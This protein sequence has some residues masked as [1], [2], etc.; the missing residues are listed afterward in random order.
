MALILWSSILL[1]HRL[2]K[3][4]NGDKVINFSENR[5]INRLIHENIHGNFI[6]FQEKSP[7]NFTQRDVY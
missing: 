4:D 5:R 7:C 6:F 3:I 2:T 1:H